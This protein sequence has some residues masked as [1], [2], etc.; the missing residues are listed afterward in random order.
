M[1]DPMTG[2]MTGQR[3]QTENR[4]AE[5]PATAG[6]IPHVAMHGRAA[7]AADFYIRAFGALDRGRLPLDDAPGQLIH[8][9]LDVNGGGLM[10]TDCVAPGEPR[11]APQGFHLQLVVTD[12]DFWWDRAVAAGCTVQVPLQ[13]MFWG[14][15]W[16]MLADPFGLTWAIDEPGEAR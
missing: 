7:E 15:R 6:V 5:A 1:P 16:G 9:Q 14:D 2:P 10:M 3:D 12:A 13:R 8:C 11:L 4:P